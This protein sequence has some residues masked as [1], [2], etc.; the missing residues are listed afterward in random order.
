MSGLLLR[1]PSFVLAAFIAVAA[2]VY[3]LAGR[4][5]P[6]PWILIDELLHA[7]LARGLRARDGFAVRG[8]GISVSW[9]YPALLAPF[10]WSYG[11]MKIVNSVVIA[12]TAVPVYLWTRRLVS[13]LS[14]L[15]AAV[16]TL[17]LP[18]MLFSSTLMLENLF[19]PLF[20]VACFAISAAVERPTPLS[21]GVALAAI[22]L[23]SA[24][25][26]QGLLLVPVCVLVAVTLRRAR[27]LAPALAVC[28]AVSVAV[29]A[30]L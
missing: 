28:A 23:A 21:Q 17:L 8:H 27:S 24:T 2:A 16:L 18:S 30:K 13:P 1:A 15:V 14:A 9:T 3:A 19:L 12:L 5:I 7:E 25:R 20:V 10:A 26:A 11:A 6:T 4:G 29:V 22:A